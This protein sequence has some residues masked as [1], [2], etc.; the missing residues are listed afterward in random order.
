MVNKIITIVGSNFYAKFK[1]EFFW[2]DKKGEYK[3]KYIRV[4]KKA[5]TNMNM[6]I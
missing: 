1:F 3:Y 4:D 5:N 2:V 6:N